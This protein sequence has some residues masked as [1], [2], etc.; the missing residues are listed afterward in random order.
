VVPVLDYAP[1][2]IFFLEKKYQMAPAANAVITV[3]PTHI[4]LGIIHLGSVT[5][6]Y[7]DMFEDVM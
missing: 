3:T 7:Q 6:G 1:L 5:A 2:S 4:V